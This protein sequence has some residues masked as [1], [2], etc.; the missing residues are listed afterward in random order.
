MELEEFKMNDRFS[1]PNV[2]EENVNNANGLGGLI[3]ELKAADQKGKKLVSRF[4]IIIFVLLGVYA[5]QIATNNGP[6]SIGYELLAAGFIFILVY[7]FRKIILIRRIDYSAP[8]IIF[9]R[10][11]EKR[12][13]FITA[14]DWFIIIPILGVLGTGGGFIVYY[15]FIKYFKDSPWPLVIY[16]IFFVSVIIFGF[17]AGKKDWKKENGVILDKIKRSIAE[18]R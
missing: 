18:N 16:I 8:V 13:T 17:W 10:K 12:Y 14:A 5:I 15:S 9:L 11:A 2:P 7:F 3:E 1:A 6:L 4:M